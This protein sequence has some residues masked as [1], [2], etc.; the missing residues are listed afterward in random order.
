M[1]TQERKEERTDWRKKD[2]N[3]QLKKWRGGKKKKSKKYR[4]RKKKGSLFVLWLTCG[5]WLS[6]AGSRRRAAGQITERKSQ[7]GDRRWTTP[8][9]K[10]SVTQRE[11]LVSETLTSEVYSSKN[12][13]IGLMCVCGPPA[14]PG[15][16]YVPRLS[17]IRRTIIQ[18]ASIFVCLCPLRS[19]LTS[20]PP[21]TLSSFLSCTRWDCVNI[22]A[23]EMSPQP[24][25]LPLNYE[26]LWTS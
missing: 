11:Q 4:E 5:T 22:A 20:W 24:R 17:T 14:V 15:R 12:D 2:G 13:L 25:R 9:S 19:S 21:S 16:R 6:G 18:S 26:I 7:C 8:L 23:D 1:K 3:E 10:P